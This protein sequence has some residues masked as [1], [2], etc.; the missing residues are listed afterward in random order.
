M[1]KCRKNEKK[2]KAKFYEKYFDNY[3]KRNMTIY[4]ILRGLVLLTL[5]RQ[6]FMG[7]WN[8][9]FLC[10]LTLVLFI[11]PAVIEKKMNLALPDALQVLILLF[12]YS[13]EILGEINEFYIVIPHWDTILHT[14]NGF[15]CAAVGFSTI[16][17][18][19]QKEFFHATMSPLFVALV[20]F[21]FSMTIGVMWEFFEF[22]VDKILKYDMQKDVI[23]DTIS[24][25]KLDPE[26]KN[27]AIIVEN[28][29]KTILQSKD[30]EGK[31]KEIEIKGGYLDIGINDT[32]Q[33]LIVNFIGAIVFSIL[34]LLYISNRD[35]YKF[36]ENFIPKMR[37]AKQ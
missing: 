34:G 21:C 32:M 8:N 27:N 12:I 10:G 4:F 24:T 13:A 5:L 14:I 26:G 16:D 22:G 15:L 7:N 37:K 36:A 11:I 6:I 18:L 23:V 1:I 31:I 19:N 2:V 3:S 28:I 33:D 25:V 9:V 20:A 35:K 30:K 17:I 29:N